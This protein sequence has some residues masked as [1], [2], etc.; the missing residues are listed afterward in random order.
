MLDPLRCWGQVSR[1]VGE[2]IV[3]QG[4]WERLGEAGR[5]WERL[6]EAGMCAVQQRR[7]PACPAVS[8]Q[9]KGK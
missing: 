8:L 6:G 9:A 4:G 1:S 7:T 5:G 2:S 3:H